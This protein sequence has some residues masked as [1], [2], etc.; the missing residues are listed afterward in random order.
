MVI[1][2][3]RINNSH[4]TLEH[5]YHVYQKIGRQVG[6]PCVYWFG[7]EAGYNAMAMEQLGESLQDI[8][9]RAHFQFSVKTVAILASQLVSTHVCYAN[10]WPDV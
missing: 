10:A 7:L 3:E 5:E 4:Q 2:L 6:I 9:T 8:F 1:K